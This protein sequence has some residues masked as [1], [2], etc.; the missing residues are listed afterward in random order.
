[1]NVCIAVDHVGEG[2]LIGWCTC[3]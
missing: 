2:S 3:K 1:M